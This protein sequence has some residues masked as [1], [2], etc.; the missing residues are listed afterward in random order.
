M[1]DVHVVEQVGVL[2]DVHRVLVVLVAAPDLSHLATQEREFVVEVVAHHHEIDSLSEVVLTVRCI[3]AVQAMSQA[4]EDLVG[5]IA[6]NL[7]TQ[8][9]VGKARRPLLAIVLQ[10]AEAA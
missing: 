9:L 8:V 5:E 7:E 4:I 6:L 10:L 2:I 3:R 1:E